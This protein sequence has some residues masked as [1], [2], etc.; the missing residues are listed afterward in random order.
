MNRFLPSPYP[1]RSIYFGG[2]TPSYLPSAQLSAI[3]A[4]L[5]EH[6]LRVSATE[7]TLEV[8]PGTANADALIELRQA[9]FNRLSIGLQASQ[10]R[11]LKTL[12]RIHGWNDF[13]QTYNLAREIGFNNI[14]IDLIFGLPGQTVG[15]WEETL[16]EVVSLNP[17]HI[18]AYGLQIE[19][20]TP[21][22]RMA[23]DGRLTL[24]P[25]VEVVTMLKTAMQFL[26]ERGY[27]RYEISNYARPG[28]ESIHNLGYWRG[29]PYLGFGA[30]AT[31]T[32]NQERWTNCSDPAR[33]ISLLADGAPV[34]A[35]REIIDRQVAATE[36]MM[37]G[38]RMSVGVAL[39]QFKKDYFRLSGTF[40]DEICFLEGEGFIRKV[41]NHL[42]LTDNAIPVSNEVIA[43]LLRHL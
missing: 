19:E 5:K 2:G 41:G 38:L 12:G 8:N 39:E 10:D 13:L 20:N 1:V 6:F 40:R 14:G 15:D 18:S 23:E 31:S 24:P 33:Y 43:R 3:L 42:Q 9:G 17:E 30:G 29:E 36:R 35:E 22:G 4:Y 21:F 11:L 37:L 32:L 7:I 28:F 27:S 26:P 16:T 25:E 34:I